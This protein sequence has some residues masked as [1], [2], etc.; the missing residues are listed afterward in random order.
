MLITRV[1]RDN[2]AL[3]VSSPSRSIYIYQTDVDAFYRYVTALASV[4]ARVP[5]MRRPHW[6]ASNPEESRKL[7][8]FCMDH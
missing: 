5:Q 7:S 2:T 3:W 1:C 4:R 8:E 6:A